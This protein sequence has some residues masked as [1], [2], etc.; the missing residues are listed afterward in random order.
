MNPI[1]IIEQ[2]YDRHSKAFQILVAHGKQVAQKA[3]KVA[4]K[5]PELKPDF[6]F[7]EKA[8]ILH[9]IGIFLTDA[10]Q[11]GCNGIHPY[12]CHGVLGYDLLIDAEKPHLA[13]VCERHVGVGISLDDVLRFNL[14]L[15]ERDMVPVSIE[16]QIVCYADKFFSK[17]GNG[18]QNIPEKPVKEIICNLRK[19]GQDK[20]NRFQKWVEL[21][22]NQRPPAGLGV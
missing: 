7:I 3:L 13:L 16:E 8:A 15:P 18:N 10:P 17:N 14:P 20:V 22:E 19:Y 4:E 6:D 9:D 11:L 21:F 2:Y 5:V 1:D 12:I